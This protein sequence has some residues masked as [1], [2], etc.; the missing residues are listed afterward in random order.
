M[1]AVADSSP[2]IYL[3]ALSD[4]ALLRELFGSVLITPAVY[5]EVV[6]QGQGFPVKKEI[7][8][9]L[10]AWLTVRPV[11]DQ[12]RAEQISMEERLEAGECEAVVLAQE[13]RAVQLLMDDRRA[14]RYARSVGIRVTRT[15]VIYAEA[16]LRGWI[17]SV[18]EKLE[19]MRH[20]GFRL[21]EG[22]Y[23]LILERVGEL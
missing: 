10:G 1:P 16:K 4:F 3:A 22:D 19:A 9:A 12:A 18:R 6:E 21:K 23:R 20:T 8:A 5:R 17:P 2:L 7:E 15:P 13:C 11:E 14:V